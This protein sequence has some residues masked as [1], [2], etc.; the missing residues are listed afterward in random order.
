M[1]VAELPRV[2][3]CAR[4][5]CSAETKEAERRVA[6][7]RT[8]LSPL[9]LNHHAILV[10]SQLVQPARLDSVALFRGSARNAGFSALFS[11][12]PSAAPSVGAGPI[13][14]ARGNAAS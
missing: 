14:C 9:G 8:F 12:L 5:C 6:H 3:F 1:R 2:Q 11:S 7:W 4:G 10:R 13:P